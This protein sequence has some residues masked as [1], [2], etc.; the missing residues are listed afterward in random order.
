M[1]QHNTTTANRGYML[2]H[3]LP[4]PP[5]AAPPRA[6]A[7]SRKSRR[8]EPKT[9]RTGLH[10]PDVISAGAGSL[11]WYRTLLKSLPSA[12]KPLGYY[13]R[14]VNC[15]QP[16][17]PDQISKSPQPASVLQYLPDCLSYGI[18]PAKSPHD[19]H[20]VVGRVYRDARDTWARRPRRGLAT[21]ARVAHGTQ[22]AA[23]RRK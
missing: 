17:R 21:R 4:A 2:K 20:V 3:N 13:Q 6:S 1:L 23:A 5:S 8:M 16:T 7:G 12:E 18:S 10:E 19:A 15:S 22:A 11:G 9:R 14:G